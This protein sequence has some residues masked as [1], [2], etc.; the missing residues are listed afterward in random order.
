EFS[1]DSAYIVTGSKFDFTVRMFHTSDGVE[2]WRR[3]LPDEIER[4]AFTRDGNYVVAGSEDFMM[5]VLSAADGDTV[6]EFA[7]QNGIDAIAAS[8]DGRFMVTGQERFE[9]IGPGRVFDTKSWDVVATVEHPGT[10]NELDFSHDDRYMASV[11]DKSARIWRVGDWT[12]HREM[13]L[14]AEPIFG[15]LDHIYINC[16]F[17]PDGKLLAV[18]GTHGFVYLF[19]VE[20]GD[21]VRRF[22]KSGQKTETVEWTLDGRYLLVAGH[23]TTIDFYRTEQLLDDGIDNDA[24]PYALRAPVTDA[25]EYMEFNAAGTL[26]TTAHQDGTV[27]LWTFMSDDPTINA[28]RHH[29]IREQQKR[30]AEERARR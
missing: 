1:P 16:K 25:L 4:V 17:S 23:G 9:G 30:S 15:N 29:E 28:R 2:V 27:Q 10:L 8:N 20:S 22:N 3:E 18:G 5:R 21:L 7:H 24:L 26:L 14:D 12:L 11:G 6:F 19:E 13:T